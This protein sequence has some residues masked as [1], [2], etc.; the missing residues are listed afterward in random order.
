MSF[1]KKREN[2]AQGESYEDKD[3]KSDRLRGGAL[4]AIAGPAS[5][6]SDPESDSDCSEDDD[7]IEELLDIDIRNINDPTKVAKYAE[8]ICTIAK[9]E[10][11][12][13]S[14][15][16]QEMHVV[17]TEITSAMRETSVKWIFDLVKEY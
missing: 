17:Q 16:L 1:T 15:R 8:K 14:G 3:L 2:A 5:D 12:E 10:L 4:H 13:R 6:Y 11:A 9:D 7:A